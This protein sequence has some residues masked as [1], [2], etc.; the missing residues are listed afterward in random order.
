MF[1][2]P[3]PH[4]H[5]PLSSYPSHPIPAKSTL[6]LDRDFADM[7]DSFPKTDQLDQFLY[8]GTD[9]YV[10]NLTRYK[11]NGLHPILLGDILPK[12]GTCVGNPDGEPRYRVLLKLGFGG[13]ATVWL[14]RDLER[15]IQ[16]LDVF[17]I[18]GPN[19]FHECLVTEVV[20]SLNNLYVVDHCSSDTLEQFS[21]D[22]I[23]EYFANP[24]VIP[25]VPRDASFPLSSV[26]PYVTPCVSIAEFLKL[27]KCFPIYQIMSGDELICTRGSLNDY[28]LR[29][30]RLGGPPPDTW[31]DISNV[32]N[33]HENGMMHLHAPLL[34]QRL[35]H[36][37]K[38][39]PR[40]STAEMRPGINA[41][42]EVVGVTGKCPCF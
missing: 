26:P 21:E 2:L 14:A 29:A 1:C 18:Q 38:Q 34:L 15:I 4:N 13:F 28:L 20:S 9:G 27:M 17:T 7:D 23:T 36:S 40:T 12:P 32:E 24:E 33:G 37:D 5:P 11:R 3:H 25:V 8:T 35:K 10:E 22:Q 42:L 19:G 41:R 6:R 30:V 39:A 16:L 31:P